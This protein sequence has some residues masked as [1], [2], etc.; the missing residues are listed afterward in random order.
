MI[1][2]KNII[3]LIATSYLLFVGFSS[4]SGGDKSILTIKSSIGGAYVIDSTEIVIV[5]AKAYNNSKDT[6]SFL[7]MSC[8]R[9]RNWKIKSP[10]LQVGLFDCYSD[11]PT[12]IKLGP[13]QYLTN[14]IKIKLLKPLKEIINEK[15]IIGFN[16]VE[17][18]ELEFTQSMKLIEETNN[19]LWSTDTLQLKSL[20]MPNYIDKF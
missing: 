13:N 9:E 2:F 12:L 5:V 6:I 7:T 15:I 17:A 10:N 20:L 11:V 18:K 3:V 14:F 1:C 19:I 4:C 8:A 16:L